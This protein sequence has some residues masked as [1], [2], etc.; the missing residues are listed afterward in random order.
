MRLFNVFKDETERERLVTRSRL[1]SE[2][3]DRKL[4]NVTLLL[5][6][7]QFHM[8]SYL[9]YCII[10]ICPTAYHMAVERTKIS[11]IK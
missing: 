3:R 5:A 1:A 10:W 9:H 4:H 11:Y 8:W 7:Q 2:H 6:K